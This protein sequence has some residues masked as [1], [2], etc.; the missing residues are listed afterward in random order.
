VH[1]LADVHDTSLSPAAAAGGPRIDWIAHVEPFQCSTSNRS[2]TNDPNE[3]LPDEPTATQALE[4]VHDTPSS[5]LSL[6]GGFGLGWIVQLVPSHRST[7]VAR[8]LFAVL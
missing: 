6:R 5:S 8:R 4:D 3:E 2:K 7:S 1:A